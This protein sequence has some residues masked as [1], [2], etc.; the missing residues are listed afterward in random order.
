MK[1]SN[2]TIAILFSLSAL[3]AFT[4]Y[5]IESDRR[6]TIQNNNG[7]LL[8]PLEELDTL[9]AQ[10]PETSPKG[11]NLTPK[12]AYKSDAE[13]AEAENNYYRNN[14]ESPHS[15]SKVVGGLSRSQNC[16]ND[17]VHIGNGYCQSLECYPKTVQGCNYYSEYNI[18]QSPSFSDTG[19]EDDPRLTELGFR[20]QAGNAVRLGKRIIKSD[21]TE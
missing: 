14:R 9:E 2:S 17:F 7:G 18:C 3:A 10:V 5:S 8:D 13:M 11:K 19:Y 4:F 15:S 21:A 16:P 6:K 12:S 20:C 1:L